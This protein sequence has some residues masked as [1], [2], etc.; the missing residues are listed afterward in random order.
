M[1]ALD[2]IGREGPVAP[3]ELARSMGFTTGGVTTVVDRLERAGY[4]RR[5]RDGPDR[6]RLTV[7]ATE[8]TH[9]RDQAVF[10]RLQQ[11]TARF[12]RAYGEDELRVVDGF[13]DGMR[14]VVVEY[15]M[16]LAPT[17]VPGVPEA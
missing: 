14:N 10:G 17:R 1:R 5:C 13:L 11:A 4:V 6:R 7:E 2:I 16:A 12:L 9:E 3:T 15:T 8:A